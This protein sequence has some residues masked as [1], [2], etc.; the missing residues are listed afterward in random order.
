M[1]RL[2]LAWYVNSSSLCLCM[3]TSA[4]SAPAL[5]QETISTD[6]TQTGGTYT[7]TGT[8]A[9]YKG[10][11]FVTD[12]DN[13]PTLML[14]SGATWNS[15]ALVVGG[16]EDQTGNLLI[17][18][19][20]ALINTL[21]TPGGDG[22]T[23]FGGGVNIR[24]GQ[25]LLGLLAGA[26]GTATVTGP[27]S[28]WENSSLLAVGNS[29]MGVLAIEDGAMVTST[30]GTI[31][32][33]AGS[34]GSVT[35]S[36][37]NSQWINSSTM[38]V[39]FLGSGTLSI[40]GGLVSNAVG[41]I[42]GAEGGS[43]TVL[44]SGDNS[45]WQNSSDLRVGFRDIGMLTIEA[46][47][48]VTSNGSTIGNRETGI[49]TVHVTGAGSQWQ[50]SREISLGQSGS[51]TLSILDGGVVTITSSGGGTTLGRFSGSEGSV[52][53]SGTGS[54][55]QNNIPLYVGVEGTGTLTIDNGGF[56]SNSTGNVAYDTG[57]VGTVTV[58]GPNSQWENS[59]NLA[60]GSFD[61]DSTGMVT[62]SGGGSISVGGLLF[63]GSGSTLNVDPGGSIDF[64]GSDRIINNGVINGPIDTNRRIFGSGTFSDLTVGDGTIVNPGNSPG[65]MSTTT[66][67]WGNGGIYE[68]ETTE[69]EGVA[70]TD[71]D[72]WNANNLGIVDSGAFTIEIKPID[73]NSNPAA[74]AGWDPTQSHEWLIGTSTNA[75]FTDTA[76]LN[77]ELDVSE[78]MSLHDLA[79]G[80][81]GLFSTDDKNSLF[82]K[83]TAPL[84][85]DFDA[86][87]IW[88]ADD[89]DLLA[90]AAQSGSTD[91]FF[92]LNNDGMV[93][94]EIGSGS[95]SDYWLHTLLGSEY[96][97]LDLDGVIDGADFSTLLG[98]FGTTSGWA[99][100]N[101]DGSTVVDGADFSTLLG[102][103]GFTSTASLAAS[104]V[105]EPS[106]LGLLL[107]ALSVC[108]SSARLSN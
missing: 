44:V 49:G 11:L 6:T 105:P 30:A 16:G 9:F 7:T 22:G 70:G 64:T 79:D 80:S 36:D 55:W 43:G 59:Q 60:I 89:L 65:S 67:S 98:N 20:S 26:T 91:V 104:T 74:L 93:T 19:G 28:T 10:F 100:G 62:V 4:L 66:T 21:D 3:L 17:Q 102:N 86:D 8:N 94:F 1:N 15:R 99:A 51:G 71:W 23:F 33:R 40:Y 90:A 88:D 101:I 41:S 54:Q 25:A 13:D 61:G 37:P 14:Q 58:T 85:G 24:R 107:L 27:G 57:S 29:G 31:G 42:A 69:V 45:E 47:G 75:A 83:F 108:V 73:G 50:S 77:L 35:I 106:T 2:A 92:D 72:L 12:A 87:G 53:V 63:I 5:G 84:L 76:L 46:G 97:D 96:G 52:T 103:F 48:T 78:F 18:G 56:V 39:G 38:E 34:T 81:F 82:L 32:V 68:W 95:D